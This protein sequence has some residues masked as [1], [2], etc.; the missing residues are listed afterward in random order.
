LA[1]STVLISSSVKL[2]CLI[3]SDILEYTS[4]PVDIVRDC[5]AVVLVKWLNGGRV[6]GLV[7]VLYSDVGCRLSL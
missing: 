7:L 3:F 2:S 1:F 5:V 4:V 6:F